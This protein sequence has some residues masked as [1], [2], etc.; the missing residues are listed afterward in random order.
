VAGPG[1]AALLEQLCDNRVARGPGRITYTQM[2]NPRGGIECDFTVTQVDEETFQIVSGTALAGHDLSW[3]TAHAPRDGSVSVRDVTSAWVCYGLWGPNARAILQP[4]T[5]Q[6]LA[7]ADFPYMTMRQTTVA[8]A[9]ARLLRVT[10]VGELGWEIYAPSEYGATLWRQLREAGAGH[11]LLPCGYRAIDSLRAEKGYRYWGSDITGDETPYEAGLGFCVRMDKDFVG[12]DAL[13]APGADR[14]DRVL[15]CLTLDDPR[16]L[17]LGNEPIR[18]AGATVGR[19]TSGAVGYH[20]GR[21]IAFGYLPAGAA[22]PGT[23]AEVLIFGEWVPAIVAAEPLFD[24][25]GA[26]I[27]S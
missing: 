22:A 9:P 15:A 24:P 10:F 12:R 1:A 21:S 8:T 6:S 11:G 5:P 20:V 3:I 23:A 2:L 27:R 25:E 26:R 4:L 17:V 7:G 16:R 13:A 18:V 19:V 14:P